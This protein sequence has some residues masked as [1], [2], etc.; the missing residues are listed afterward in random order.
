MRY[1]AWNSIIDMEIYLLWY[2]ERKTP[3]LQAMLPTPTIPF[4]VQAHFTVWVLGDRL[5]RPAGLRRLFPSLKSHPSCHAQTPS[6]TWKKLRKLTQRGP[7][8]EETL[9]PRWWKKH[10]DIW[11]HM[12][13]GG[14][15]RHRHHEHCDMLNYGGIAKNTKSL[16]WMIG[17]SHTQ[18]LVVCDEDTAPPIWSVLSEEHILLPRERVIG[19][20]GLYVLREFHI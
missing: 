9:R 13:G 18:M 12:E 1:G 4:S 10:G 5:I 16:S 14:E 20:W 15:S 8:T 19:L 11:V 3:A 17:P 2:M 7:P 6:L